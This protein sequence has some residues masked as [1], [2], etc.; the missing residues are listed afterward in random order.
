MLGLRV[1]G[2][3]CGERNGRSL[4]GCDGPLTR[5][6]TLTLTMTM[7]LILTC[8]GLRRCEGPSALRATHEPRA[9]CMSALA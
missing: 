9:S 6:Q 1:L 5:T 2:D 8:R 4:R 3:A 7:T